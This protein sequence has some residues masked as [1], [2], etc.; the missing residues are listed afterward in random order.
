MASSVVWVAAGAS[1]GVSVLECTV[2]A[3]GGVPTGGGARIPTER[4]ERTEPDSSMNVLR[5]RARA[6]SG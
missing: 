3:R 5:V 6:C 2:L 4:T 1:Q